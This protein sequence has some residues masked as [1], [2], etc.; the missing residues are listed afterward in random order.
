M[1]PQATPPLAGEPTQPV[2][3]STQPVP[4]PQAPLVPTAPEVPRKSRKLLF[5]LLPLLVAGGVGYYLA[6][7]GLGAGREITYEMDGYR[8]TLVLPAG[9]EVQ[10]ESNR[11]VISPD[12]NVF[13]KISKGESYTAISLNPLASGKNTYA[14]IEGIWTKS[15]AQYIAND[16]KTPTGMF[17]CAQISEQTVDCVWISASET[18]ATSALFSSGTNVTSAFTEQAKTVMQSLTY[19]GKE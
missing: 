2:T 15:S 17:S 8:Y 11:K 1:E 6:S 16:V 14:T 18:L 13:E 12:N 3:M 9:Y 19:F 10:V 5:W 4:D 7:G